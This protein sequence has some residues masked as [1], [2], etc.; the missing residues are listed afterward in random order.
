MIIIQ[1]KSNTTTT[2]NI[3]FKTDIFMFKTA[4]RKLLPSFQQA[5]KGLA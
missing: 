5:F 4:S 3:I 2:T 1:Y